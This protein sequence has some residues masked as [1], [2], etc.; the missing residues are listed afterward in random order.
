ML[1]FGINTFE[2][3]CFLTYLLRIQSLTKTCFWK[4][5]HS[6]SYE[7]PKSVVNFSKYAHCHVKLFWCNLCAYMF[8]ATC[9][10]RFALLMKMSFDVL[11]KNQ[12]FVSPLMLWFA[13]STFGVLS[14]L[15][16]FSKYQL[17]DFPAKQ[18]VRISQT[19]CSIVKICSLYEFFMWL[20]FFYR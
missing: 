3:L 1:Q 14:C 13:I 19:T 10:L 18:I 5:Q 20:M 7:F 12:Q 17:L 2:V 9:T 6:N 16:V 11:A 8:D 4:F 15:D